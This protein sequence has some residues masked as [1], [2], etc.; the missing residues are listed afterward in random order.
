M[1]IPPL[2]SVAVKPPVRFD[3]RTAQPSYTLSKEDGQSQQRRSPGFS[4]QRTFTGRD[5]KGK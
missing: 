1:A 3:V 2:L 4:H 5:V